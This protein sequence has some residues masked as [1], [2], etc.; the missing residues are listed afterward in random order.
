MHS[1]VTGASCRLGKQASLFYE[2]VQRCLFAPP[3]AS[4]FDK[5][6][7]AHASVK[8]AVYDTE[9]QLQSAADLHSKDEIALEICRLQVRGQ[10]GSEPG[11]AGLENYQACLQL[12][13][14]HSYVADPDESSHFI[15]VCARSLVPEQDK[16]QSLDKGKDVHVAAVL[17]AGW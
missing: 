11:S 6:W 9:A 5:S 8:A 16:H 13:L 10:A 4:H 3:L 1:V 17:F 2:E 7:T 12:Q 15:P 14:V